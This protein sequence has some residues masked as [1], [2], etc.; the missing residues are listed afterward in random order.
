[1]RAT[2]VMQR[3]PYVATEDEPVERVARLMR[4]YNVGFVPVVDDRAGM[5]LRGVITERD[6]VV[7]HLA[8]GSP[9]RHTA[10]EVMTRY[11]W[12][13]VGPDDE[14]EDALYRMQRAGVSRA[15]VVGD[16]QRLLGIVA[17]DDLLTRLSSPRARAGVIALPVSGEPPLA[18]C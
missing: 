13:T 7:R 4:D 11:P 1:M 15:L 3:D 16:E 18:P 8:A 12:G 5:R 2:D 10:R 17:F 9:G 14:I 6:L